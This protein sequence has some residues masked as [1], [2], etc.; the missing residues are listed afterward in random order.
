MKEN[1]VSLYLKMVLF[2]LTSLYALILQML[3]Q[4]YLQLK[5]QRMEDRMVEGYEMDALVIYL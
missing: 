3:Q 2:L 1:L 5:P 4:T